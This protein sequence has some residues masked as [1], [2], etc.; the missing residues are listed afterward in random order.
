[1]SAIPKD[2]LQKTAALS[3]EVTR[4]FPNSQ[5]IYIT[6][7]RPDIRVGM[8]QVIQAPTPQAKGAEENPPI[9]LYDTSGPYTDPQERS[10]CCKV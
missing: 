9:I 8:R 7:S 10:T 4:P 6:G 5:K 3:E 2:F 1:M